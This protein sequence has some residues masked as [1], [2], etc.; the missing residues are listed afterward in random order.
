MHDFEHLFCPSQLSSFSWIFS[1]HIIVLQDMLLSICF[2][3]RSRGAWRKFFQNIKIYYF[4]IIIHECMISS[5]CFVPANYQFFPGFF[6]PLLSCKTWFFAFV[7][8]PTVQVHEVNFFKTWNS[9]ISFVLATTINF[10]W[11]FFHHYI[12]L[13]DMI[14]ALFCPPQ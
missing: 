8:S 13:K 14:W 6:P 5:V 7:L 1:H 12:V 2:V 11:I 10:F 9:L 3:P 4:D